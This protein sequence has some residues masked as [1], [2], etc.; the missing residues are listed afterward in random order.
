[1]HRAA[2]PQPVEKSRA[3]GGFPAGRVVEH[4]GV[5]PVGGGDRGWEQVVREMF[6]AAGVGQRRDVARIVEPHARGRGQRGRVQLVR[7]VRSVAPNEGPSTRAR[8]VFVVEIRVE[9]HPPRGARREVARRGEHPAGLR[10]H[11]EAGPQPELAVEGD[12]RQVDHQHGERVKRAG[13]HLAVKSPER[14]P[15]LQRAG[16]GQRRGDPQSGGEAGE[17]QFHAG[18]RV[19]SSAGCRPSRSAHQIPSTTPKMPCALAV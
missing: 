8:V 10:S 7:T 11:R 5:Q 14:L 18:K 19:G 13:D 17:E 15:Y 3:P 4:G 16:C 6:Q 12:R 1:M 9:L 2:A